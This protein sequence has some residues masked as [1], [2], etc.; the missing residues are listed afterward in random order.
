MK[1]DEL[2]GKVAAGTGCTKKMTN[3]IVTAMFQV[4]E[5]Q[6]TKGETIHWPRFGSFKVVAREEKN[7]RNPSTGQ[8][9]ISPAHRIVKFKVANTL[10]EAVR[11]S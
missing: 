7:V 6:L 11:G 4:I 9:M 1:K 10:R 5:G 8:V 2:I 3:E